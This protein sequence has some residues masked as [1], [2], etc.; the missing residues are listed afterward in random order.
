MIA[1]T[2][3][4]ARQVRAVFR[5]AL[6]IT[7]RGRSMAVSF[8]TGPDGLRIRALSWDAAV[9]YH[10]PGDHTIEQ[11]DLPFEFLADCEGRKDE[12]VQLSASDNGRVMAQWRDGSVPQIVQYDPATPVDTAQ[13]PR[14]PEKV[15]TNPIAI[16][17][18]LHDATESTD[19]APVRFAT[20]R[21]QLRGKTGVIVATDGQQLLLQSGFQFPWED[22]LLV[23][24]SKAFGCAEWIGCESATVGRSEKWFSLVVGPWTVH[25]AL[26]V[27]LRFPEVDRNVPKSADAVAH[28]QL[29][30][31]D[32]QFLVKALPRLPGDDEYDFPATLDLNGRVV[33]RGKGA[34]HPRPTDVI[35]ANSSWSGEPIRINTNRKYLARALQLGFDR[36]YV[37][38]PQRPI[39]CQD[40]HRQY[41][42]APLHPDSAIAQAKDAIQIVSPTSEKRVSIPTPKN[43][44]T[45][46]IPQTMSEPTTPQNGDA[47]ANGQA[48]RASRRKAS[49][50]DLAA[51]I[52]Q[53]ES[54]R[55]TLKEALSKTTGLIKSLKQHRRQSRIVAST[56]ESLRQLKTMGV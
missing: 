56:L 19:P 35:L 47:K 55:T 13:F 17:K 28:C 31:D 54:L 42:W 29:S 36:L 38:D 22:D 44:K 30:A 12:P 2:R 26:G 23:P 11:A 52:Q 51:L 25:L 1:I 16:L 7:P 15:A 24:A 4:L 33:I 37:Y 50:Q 45:K 40:D 46:R 32:V 3:N 27:D 21:I 18:A 9:E 48:P 53:A 20:D 5:R 49:R 34:D 43:H 6:N 41:V 10:V 8:Q 39:L 14:M